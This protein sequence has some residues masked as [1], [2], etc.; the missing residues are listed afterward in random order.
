MSIMKSMTWSTTHN[1]SNRICLGLRSCTTS[2]S[3]SQ[4]RIWIIYHKSK[5]D[6]GSSL[7]TSRTSSTTR[8]T[9]QTATRAW[10]CIQLVRASP[11]IGR[12]RSPPSYQAQPAFL[13]LQLGWAGSGIGLTQS[14]PSYPIPAHFSVPSTPTTCRA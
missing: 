9:Y 13:R 14:P 12:A 1:P 8:Y 10:R 4:G 6:L 11:G 5:G 2:S 7:P 3:L